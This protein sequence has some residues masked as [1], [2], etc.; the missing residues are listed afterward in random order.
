M[1][2]RAK[3]RGFTLIE[4]MVVIAI[5]GVL[6]AVAMPIFENMG[7]KDTNR[8]A[9]QVMTTMRLA[10]QHAVA[11]RQW[12]LLVIPNRDG[13]YSATSGA[14]NSIDKCLR[15]YAVLAVVNSMDGYI[16]ADQTP[17][18]M[19]FEF[20][21]DWKYL[22]EGIYF[23]EDTKLTGNFIFSDKSTKFNYPLDPSR[24]DA[25]LQQPMS[26]MMFQP[27]GRAFRMAGG[28][29]TGKYWQDSDYSRVYLTSAK[30]Y[31]IDGNKLAKQTSIPGT[32]T[33]I[34]IRNKTGQ[35]QILDTQSQ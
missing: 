26:V 2:T 27:N 16:R 22:P 28:T 35:V 15:S 21:S 6:F 9:Y 8:A 31:E 29:T 30:Y 32:N 33:I 12:T 18:N 11:K 23:D 5:I 14:L 1:N 10:R 24:P 20:V 17:D 34:Q 3:K 13:S 25:S 19:E 4:L 7:R